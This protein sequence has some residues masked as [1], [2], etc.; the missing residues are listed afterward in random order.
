MKK[1]LLFKG[2]S[3]LAL[4]FIL[5]YQVINS[6][7]TPRVRDYVSLQSPGPL[8]MTTPVANMERVGLFE[9]FE[10]T[11]VLTG[12]WDNPF[13]PEQIRVD[14]QFTA[15][16]RK[17]YTVPGFFYQEYRLNVQNRHEKVGEPVWKIRFTPQMTGTYSY[18]VIAVN[19]GAE[20]KS[21]Q[22]N[23]TCVNFN[24]SHGYLGISKTNPLYLEFS[25]GTPFFGIAQD[26]SQGESR[27][28]YQRFANVGGNFN[29]LFLTN[30]NFNIEE[31][32][33]PSSGSDM[34]LG[35]MNQE[36][37]WNLD[38]LLEL[39]E[40]LGIYHML[41]IT[42]Q[43]TF[44]QV[45][46]GHAYNKANGGILDSK[47][48]Y[49]T[50]E[51]AMKYFERRLRYHVARWGYSTSVFSWDLWNE[52]SAMGAPLENA[53][54][55]HKRMA[56]YLRSI[57][58]FGHVIHTNDGSFNGRDEM[59]SM[60][61]MELVSTNTYGINDI[62][63]LGELWTKK[64]ISTYK[65]PYILT[66]F[67]MWHTA[68]SVGGYAA[69][70]PERRMVHDGLWSPIVSGA[71]A[72]G[73]AWEGNWLDH[74][75]F[76]T[77]LSAVS[78]IVDGVPFSKRQWK[79]ATVSSFTFAKGKAPYYADV[80]LEGWPGNFAM[81]RDVKPEFFNINKEG[82]ADQHDAMNAVLTGPVGSKSSNITSS[83]TLKVDFPVDGEFV[84]YVTDMRTPEPTPRLEVELDG[85]QALRKDLTPLQKEKYH[86]MMYNQAFPV[87]VK[88]GPHTIKIS[89][90][91]GGSFVT[92]FELKKFLLRNG[93]D[94]E[95]RGLQ[96]DDF[97][98]LW[99]KNPK[100]TVL[101]EMV[102]IEFKEQPEGSLVLSNVPDG[103]WKAEW[104]NTIN[105][106]S[107]RSEIVLSSKG[108]LLL[109]T[110]SIRESV[111]VRLEKIPGIPLAGK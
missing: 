2:L 111:A 50:N 79:P 110:P 104:V 31:L 26:R 42:N 56:H 3:M 72:T 29:R 35:K 108:K 46:K 32:N 69:M 54:K 16:D 76:Y 57:D 12:D 91:G 105:A 59:N 13:D 19:K 38:K 61:E 6:Q 64:M 96:T 4:L 45:W 37:S 34:G 66:E 73:M 11:F 67:A 78:K 94:I 85:T 27:G 70:D 10:I 88:K 20:V 80:L 93:P 15:P 106:E 82:R 103:S 51:E 9:K 86:P 23:F 90:T 41:T 71:A 21:A 14:A 97:I 49:F 87:S 25:D 109:K 18:Q 107:I 77:Y 102:G 36:T 24:A 39:G 7:N 101:H 40:K 75:L 22:G 60:P 53:L 17:Q 81:P 48:E 8:A 95:A 28:C 68:G 98:L 30:G 99:L 43:W 55:W 47:N 44:N 65:K 33:V 83:V 63:Y 5:P 84:I 100:Y 58:P 1:H 92:A 52:Y 74:E 62:A 89:N